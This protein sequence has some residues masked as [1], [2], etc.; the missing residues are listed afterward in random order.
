MLN[1]NRIIDKKDITLKNIL[2]VITVLIILW[3]LIKLAT[4]VDISKESKKELESL[5]SH[6]E[7][8][9]KQQE[10][11][12]EEIEVVN[13]EIM[14]VESRVETIKERKIEISNEFGKKISD[15]GKFGHAELDS[16]FADRYKGLY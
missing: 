16:F 1:F 8:I 10:T 13:Q 4:V 6:I 14:V 15:A 11:I 7:K 3:Y 5:Q 2:K 12:Q 9:E